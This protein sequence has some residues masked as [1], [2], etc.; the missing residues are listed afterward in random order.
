M[1]RG[2][3][4]ENFKT[5][6]IKDDVQLVMTK[7]EILKKDL[8]KNCAQRLDLPQDTVD[9]VINCFFSLMLEALRR[10]EVVIIKNLGSFTSNMQK[11]RIIYSVKLGRRKIIPARKVVTF[12][13]R[14]SF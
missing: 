3:T 7:T 2:R 6:L 1:G 4:P 11:E 9:E 10:D 13:S 5:T 14:I 8:S 12:K